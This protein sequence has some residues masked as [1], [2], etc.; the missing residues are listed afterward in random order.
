MREEDASN[1]GRIDCHVHYFASRFSEALVQRMLRMDPV[2]SV[3]ASRPAWR[4]LSVHLDLMDQAGVTL[5]VVIPNGSDL[6]E[7]LR[8]L[9]GDLNEALDA[10]HE[11]L[12]DDLARTNGRLVAA[13]AVDPRGGK[14]ALDG[15]ERALRLP[16]I[17]GIGLVASYDGV[18]L[19]DPLFEPILQVARDFDAPILVHPSSVAPA[20]V[21]AL[22]LDNQVLR[23]GLGFL[24]DDAMCIL[25]M[26]LN[27]TFDT[28]P[29]VR[30]MFCQLGGVAPFCCGRWEYHRHQARRLEEEK[31]IRRPAWVERSLAD[32]LSHVWLDTHTQDRHALA[33]VLAELGEHVAV[34]GGDHPYTPFERGIPYA[35]EEL[36]GLALSTETRRNVERENAL[37]LLGPR[38]DVAPLP[39]V[40]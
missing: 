6:V 20:W 1:H 24:L 14:A 4:D 26:A 18:A 22:R 8:S 31:G 11:S 25:R 12:S 40:E 19:D 35:L 27:G 21:D 23:T 30:F 13:A 28:Y 39:R 15:L 33:L 38:L 9:G 10:Y 3:V 34:L 17:V 29:D 16:S 36:D 7:G 32:Y 37:R 5:G 2:R